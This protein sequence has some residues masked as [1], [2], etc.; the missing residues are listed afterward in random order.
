MIGT[1]VLWIAFT[2]S[3]TSAC[4]YYL[5]LSKQNLLQV[6]RSSFFISVIGVASV[7]AILLLYILQHRFEYHYVSSYSS[8]DLPTALLITTF[9]AGQ[10]GSFLLW[11]LFAAVIGLFLQAY[12]RR[13]DMERPAMATYSLV[14]AFLLLLIAIK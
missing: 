8:R 3:L 11:A 1:T 14:L 12:T 6:A 4:F 7:S 13:T 9:W 2:A 5:S 10:E